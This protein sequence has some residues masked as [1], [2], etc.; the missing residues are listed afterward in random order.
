MTSC[1]NTGSNPPENSLTPRSTA[2]TTV[3][4]RPCR[5]VTKCTC[6]ESSSTL[7]R[8]GP[9]ADAASTTMWL[10]TLLIRSWMRRCG[11]GVEGRVDRL[12][13]CANE[14]RR[15]VGH[16]I[17]SDA[18]WPATRSRPAR[19]DP[20]E[21]KQLGDVACV[22]VDG[23]SVALLVGRSHRLMR[24]RTTTRGDMDEHDRRP[25]SHRNERMD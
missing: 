2:R 14:P 22:A 8:C 16:R 7:P 10:A 23:M 11:G 6:Q 15:W 19:A 9:R 24:Y 3:N 18:G 25:R 20:I 12:R 17:E 5:V 4:V 13:V 21:I 1:A